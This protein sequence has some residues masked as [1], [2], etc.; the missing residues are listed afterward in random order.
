M[1]RVCSDKMINNIL[2]N[3]AIHLGSESDTYITSEYRVSS[4]PLKAEFLVHNIL[5]LSSYLTRNTFH[6]GYED[7]PVK[8]LGK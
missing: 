5:T 6:L 7:Q 8:A 4:N 1:Q 2:S 3:V